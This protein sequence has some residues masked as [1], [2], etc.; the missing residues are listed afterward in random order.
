MGKPE[1]YPKPILVR[2]PYTLDCCLK[3]D[4]RSNSAYSKV[5]A[6]AELP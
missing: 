2:A 1:T 4:P 5:Y 6:A 3:L